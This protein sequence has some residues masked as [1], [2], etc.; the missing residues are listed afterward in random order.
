MAPP[1]RLLGGRKKEKGKAS[2]INKAYQPKAGEKSISKIDRERIKDVC[3]KNIFTSGQLQ[4]AIDAEKKTNVKEELLLIRSEIFMVQETKKIQQKNMNEDKDFSTDEDDEEKEQ[5]REVQVNKKVNETPSVTNQTYKSL[6]TSS[7]L[8]PSGLVNL[9]NTCFM[10]SALQCCANLTNFRQD[11]QTYLDSDGTDLIDTPF[12][13]RQVTFSRPFF[14]T[15]NKIKSSSG[16]INPSEFFRILQKNFCQ[17]SGRRQQDSHEF[18]IYSM[19]K[20]CE[21]EKNTC[22]ASV[23]K[24]FGIPINKDPSNLPKKR[25]EE[26]KHFYQKAF[27]HLPVNKYFSGKQTYLTRCENCMNVTACEDDFFCLSLSIVDKKKMI[28]QSQT[29]LVNKNLIITGDKSKGSTCSEEESSDKNTSTCNRRKKIRTKTKKK[30]SDINVK[31]DNLNYK[32]PISPYGKQMYQ[33]AMEAYD[34]D[35]DPFWLPELPESGSDREVTDSDKSD[36]EISKNIEKLKISENNSSLKESSSSSDVQNDP[37]PDTKSSKPEPQTEKNDNQTHLNNLMNNSLWNLTKSSSEKFNQIFLNSNDQNAC[38]I[39]ACII[40]NSR[41]EIMNGKNMINCEKCAAAAAKGVKN[42]E[43]NLQIGTRMSVITTFPKVLVLHLKRYK[44]SSILSKGKISRGN[45][46]KDNT[47]ISFEKEIILKDRYKYK[48]NSIVEH[49]GG[50]SSGHYVA[51]V[52]IELDEENDCFYYC[53]D[54]SVR[55]IGNF[56]NV[57]PYMLFYTLVE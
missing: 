10:N 51:A 57:N 22:K 7:Q 50:L 13:Q 41:P 45:A 3:K 8:P 44:Q 33:K 20:M 42:K 48:L 16:S 43:P 15:I 14:N 37:E 23:L 38:S 28:S 31:P 55:K 47:K 5:E 26:A 12:F 25:K 30:R 21:D 52:R 27:S 46:S 4:K 19:M 2:K 35:E 17:F 29:N 6:K 56:R 24:K 54:S 39:E 11:F 40:A 53:S 1:P 32:H 18:F 9:G 34:S 49:S 36:K